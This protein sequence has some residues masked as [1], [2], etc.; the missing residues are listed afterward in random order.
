MANIKDYEDLLKDTLGDK[1]IDIVTLTDKIEV[2][3]DNCGD[4]CMNSQTRLNAFD[5]YNILKHKSVKDLMQN[6]IMYY[7]D[8]SGL[9]LIMIEDRTATC[10][11]LHAN[12]NGDFV[13][14]LGEDKPMICNAP[15]VAIITKIDNNTKNKE[16]M[17]TTIPFDTEIEP[18]DIK[19][20]LENCRITNNDLVYMRGRNCKTCH[21]NKSEVVVSDYISKRIQYEDEYNI[22]NLISMLLM[23]Y[24]NVQEFMR[25]LMLAEHSKINILDTLTGKNINKGKNHHDMMGSMFFTHAYLYAD[26]EKTNDFMKTSLEQ[27]DLLQN[28]VYPRVRLLYEYIYKVFDP[29]IETLK[30]ILHIDDE[31]E[32]QKQ[33]D[34]YYQEHIK[35]I[36]ERFVTTMPEM[37]E[38]IK[39]M[40]GSK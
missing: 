30:K 10:P 32:C 16:N 4:C 28:T 14:E 31:K 6:I 11:F 20:Y 21:S 9:P 8:S 25:L 27:L 12:N 7:G 13:C 15:F 22:A 26:P 1:D 24:I 39:K 5:V 37:L 34:T 40:E 38:R 18:I 3:C 23:R 36:S 2:G 29:K 19:Q 35:E 17:F 33:F